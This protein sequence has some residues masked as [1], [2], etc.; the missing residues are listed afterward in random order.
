MLHIPPTNYHLAAKQEP[1]QKAHLLT[2]NIEEFSGHQKA[3]L[4]TK[5]IEEF[6]GKSQENGPAG[7]KKDKAE[8][9]MGVGRKTREE[10]MKYN[11]TTALRFQ[12]GGKRHQTS[13]AFLWGVYL[14]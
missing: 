10:T 11:Q 5:N 6:S 4:L 12:T 3:Y 7:R 1:R 8:R 13:P 14:S 9:T 2:K